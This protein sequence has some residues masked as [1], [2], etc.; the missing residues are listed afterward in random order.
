MLRVP[1]ALTSFGRLVCVPLLLVLTG[2][3]SV[4]R[5]EPITPITVAPSVEIAK[6]ALGERL[7]RD[8]R[9]SHGDVVSCES[10]HR[11]EKSGDDGTVRSAVTGGV[12]PDFNTPTVFNAALNFR[13]NWRG[14]FRTI[15][16]HNEAVLLD[17]TLMNTTW[18]EL[19][20]KL[21]SDPS[22]R[23]GF[24]EVFNAPPE[25]DSV[26]D[27]LAAFQRSLITPNSRFDRYLRGD[28]TAIT[29]DEEQGYLLF[30]SYGCI[31][32]HQGM[33]VGGN[34]FQRFGIFANP[35]AS[36]TIETAGDLGRFV[37][38]RRE[39]DRHVFRVPSL[40]NVA[41]TA[42]YFHDGR[43]ATLTGAVEVMARN[44]LGRVLSESDVDLIVKFL[45]TLTGEYRGRLLTSEKPVQ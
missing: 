34:L 25:R 19:L 16:E 18:Q 45:G 26:L 40:R 10:C 5:D 20:P 3:Q 39:Q 35:F 44:Q 23:E 27:A 14:N 22:Y 13:L 42:P 37:V 2:Q 6:L 24:T 17:R 11:L 7:F 15:E 38:T 21:R 30:K 28:R 33:N 32:C 41:I 12:T 43:T 8:A 1:D 36:Q 4:P 29:A 9:L 31:A